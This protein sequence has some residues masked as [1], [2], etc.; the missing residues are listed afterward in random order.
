L[1]APHDLIDRL[2][3]IRTPGIGPIAYR[4]LLVRFGSAEAA[5]A[6]VPDLAGVA[7][8]RR[9]LFAL[10]IGQRV[11]S[12]RSRSSAHAICRSGRAYTRQAWPKLTARHH[13]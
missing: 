11:K 4:Q 7:V 6:A 5:L 3:L 12:R 13:C 8:E 10:A 1:T 2:R 9:P